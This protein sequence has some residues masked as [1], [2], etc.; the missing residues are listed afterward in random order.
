MHHRGYTVVTTV[1]IVFVLDVKYHYIIWYLYW[2][3]DVRY[4]KDAFV[5]TC[6][7][8]FKKLKQVA[9]INQ[10]EYPIWYVL[11]GVYILFV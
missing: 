5:Y 8:P 1:G 2:L 11:I 4:L 6:T 7:S 3:E 9:A 10:I